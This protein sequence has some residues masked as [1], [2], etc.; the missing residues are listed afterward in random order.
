MRE[1]LVPQIVGEGGK[2]AGG[3]V[4][5]VSLECGDGTFG[6]IAAMDIGGHKLVCGFPDVSDV[7]AV[8]LACFV[9]EDLVLY[10]VAASLEAG[11]DVGIGWD[12]VAVFASLERIDEDDVG[13]AVICD[14]EELVAAAG[15]DHE[16][17]RVVGVERA[18]GFDPEVEL[19]VKGG[20]ERVLDGDSRQGGE[21]GVVVLD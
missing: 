8:F 10:D 17:S 1:E 5:E 9:V 12:V 21:V 11:H 7:S 4:E 2:D 6:Y 13:V 18:D 14:H 3:D 19:F 20:R 15:T 16:A